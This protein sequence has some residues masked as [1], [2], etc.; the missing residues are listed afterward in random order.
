MEA[1]KIVLRK[2]DPVAIG[3]LYWINIFYNKRTHM[4]KKTENSI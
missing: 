1:T 3:I 2:E 4:K